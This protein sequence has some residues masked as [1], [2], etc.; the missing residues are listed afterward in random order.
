MDIKE[1]ILKRIKKDGKL[2]VADIVDITG[3]SRV[4]IY[5]IFKELRREGKIKLIGKANSARYVPADMKIKKPLKTHR[6]IKNQ[7]LDEDIIYDRI[8][9]ES[10]VLENAS[11]QAEEIYEYAFTE[12]LN[13]A[14]E[15]SE[16]QK[17]DI[18]AY[19]DRERMVFEINDRGIGIFNRIKNKFNLKD[20]DTAAAHLLKGKQTTAPDGHSGEGIFFVSRAADFFIIKS[21]DIKLIFD[22]KIN[23]I[24]KKSVKKRKGTRIKFE[25]ERESAKKLETIFNKYTEK[26]KFDFSKTRIYVPLFE[27]KKRYISRT[28]AKRILT[29]LENFKEITLDFKGVETVG[30][31]FTDEVFR[32]WKKAHPGKNIKVKN[33][34]PDVKFMINRIKETPR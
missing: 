20:T 7:E 31:A 10:A 5:R 12:I 22:N 19:S 18:L 21:S 6:F 3:F 34:D 9:R 8:K 15:H 32:V 14:I 23:D 17:I 26:G 4:Y 11:M 28:H 27:S 30:Q 13:N 24:F 1:I 16:S 33:A 29:G 25:I 2:K